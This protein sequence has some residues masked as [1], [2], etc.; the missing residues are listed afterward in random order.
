MITTHT[1]TTWL[2]HFAQLIETNKA[3]LTDLDSAIGDADH[4]INMA[5]GMAAV[6]AK[7]DDSAALNA[8][9]K[10]TG[11]ALV[12]SVGGA[13]GPLYSTLFMKIGAELGAA[14]EVSASDFAVALRAGLDGVMTRGKASLG[15]KTMVDALSPAVVAFE[16][17]AGDGAATAA[18]AASAAA[19]TGRD[20]TTPMVATK[21]RASYLGPRSVGHQDP[22]ATSTALLF[23]ALAAATQE[24]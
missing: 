9:F 6:V 18:A 17:A 19:Q 4:G 10:S 14:N 2:R 21:G 12:G 8:V 13:S 24:G 20:A 22:G 23:E 15:E 7:L 11:M 1:C 5:R 3:L 16:G